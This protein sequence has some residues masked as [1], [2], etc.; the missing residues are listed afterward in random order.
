MNVAGLAKGRPPVSY[1]GFYNISRTAAL[2]VSNEYY[3][4]TISSHVENG[5]IAHSHVVFTSIVSGVSKELLAGRRTRMLVDIAL[6]LACPEV[7]DVA[8]A[9][10]LVQGRPIPRLPCG[11]AAMVGAAGA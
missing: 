4:V 9:F 1:L 5:E 6:T 7:P 2:G 8:D 3:A 11:P 10:S